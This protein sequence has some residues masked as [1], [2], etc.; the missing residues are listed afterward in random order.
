M[1]TNPNEAACWCAS[2][3]KCPHTVSSKI[4]SVWEE[5]EQGVDEVLGMFDRKSMHNF[6][7]RDLDGNP[8]NAAVGK[9]KDVRLLVVVN[10]LVLTCGVVTG[11]QFKEIKS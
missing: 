2:D 8:I 7:K 9:V 10:K 3:G 5:L 4:Q 1:A 6:L 11:V